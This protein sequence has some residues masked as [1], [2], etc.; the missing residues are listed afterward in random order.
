MRLS[1]SVERRSETIINS[2]YQGWGEFKNELELFDSIPE[3]ELK[4]F[5]QVDLEMELKDF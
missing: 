5:E 3:L 4:D 2:T 1:R